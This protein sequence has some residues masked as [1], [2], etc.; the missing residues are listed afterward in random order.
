MSSASHVWYFL[1]NFQWL[2]LTVSRCRTCRH[3]VRHAEQRWCHT[4]VAVHKTIGVR[5]DRHFARCLVYWF[6]RNTRSFYS[7]TEIVRPNG[8]DCVPSL[9][10]H[11]HFSNFLTNTSYRLAHLTSHFPWNF[12]WNQF[13]QFPTKRKY[14]KWKY[15]YENTAFRSTYGKVNRMIVWVPQLC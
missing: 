12:Q 2:R 15:E 7:R 13:L 4:M 5:P 9:V 14:E 10:K 3:A 1:H 8:G 11:V 6:A